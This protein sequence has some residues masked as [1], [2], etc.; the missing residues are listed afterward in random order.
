M[1]SEN[2][3]EQSDV[4]NS[5]DNENKLKSEYGQNKPKLTIDKSDGPT[6]EAYITQCL[7]SRVIKQ[8]LLENIPET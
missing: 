8:V 4:S 1:K 5:S 6:D 3:D 2:E 7:H